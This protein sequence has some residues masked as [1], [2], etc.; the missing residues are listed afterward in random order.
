MTI[1][2]LNPVSK[3]FGQDHLY[4]TTWMMLTHN[5]LEC[6]TVKI[7]AEEKEDRQQEQICK[8]TAR[9]LFLNTIWVRFFVYCFIPHSPL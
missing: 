3:D 5:D 4:C 8:L 9:I 1:G 7:G 6:F 2:Y